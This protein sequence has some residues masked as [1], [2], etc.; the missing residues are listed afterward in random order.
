V[1]ALG[2]SIGATVA[3]HL[4]ADPNSEAPDGILLE[5]P[6]SLRAIIAR[7]GWW[8][9]WLI[10]APVWWGIP[11]SADADRSARAARPIPAL[12][13]IATQDRTI[14]LADQRRIANDYRGPKRVVDAACDHN[15]VVTA[16]C[17]PDLIAGL[18]WLL[19]RS[20]GS[21]ERPE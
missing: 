18:E 13:V 7:N 11:A 5:K 19:E 1:W 14:R 9:L 21:P 3:L 6:P 8:N 10:A 20:A 16:R 12:F 15:D 4:A 2:T 17:A